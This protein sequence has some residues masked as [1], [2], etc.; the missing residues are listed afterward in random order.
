M[1]V[2]TLAM[3][4]SRIIESEAAGDPERVA[5]VA[6][7]FGAM[8]FMPT[9]LTLQVHSREHHE[10]GDRIAFDLLNSDGGRAIRDGVV[11]LRS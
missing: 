9:E 7:R 2:A 5:R 4:V 6:C 1:G 8:V 10:D 3:S 11:V